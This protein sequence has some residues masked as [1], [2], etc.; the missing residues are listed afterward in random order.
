MNSWIY[1]KPAKYLFP[2]FHI[3]GIPMWFNFFKDSKQ[4]V[5][6]IPR[7]VGLPTEQINFATIKISQSTDF[8]SLNAIIK[9]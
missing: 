5:N 9:K 4:L 8:F 2:L 7:Y 1:Q 3:L 6:I